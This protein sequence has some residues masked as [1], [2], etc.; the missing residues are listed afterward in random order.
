MFGENVRWV[1]IHLF[2]LFQ[3][4]TIS[5]TNLN[6]ITQKKRPKIWKMLPLEWAG[7]FSGAIKG[8]CK[9]WLWEQVLQR[10]NDW[11][12]IV[13][14]VM[15][16]SSKIGAETP[17]VTSSPDPPITFARRA[18]GHFAPWL[19]AGARSA[20]FDVEKT[21]GNCFEFGLCHAEK[22]L[23]VSPRQTLCQCLA[24]PRRSPEEI[25]ETPSNTGECGR[26]GEGRASY[27]RRP[28]G[29]PPQRGCVASHKFQQK[30]DRGDHL[31]RSV[32]GGQVTAGALSIALNTF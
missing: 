29:Q 27:V 21:P 32:V 8:K 31:F 24:G 4:L 19:Q 20:R 10:N 30:S 5:N 12:Y 13:A 14:C 11:R 26:A 25:W 1:P 7:F 15:L 18:R 22:I 2:L 17:T 3:F 23:F 9:F 16:C 28:F 6:G